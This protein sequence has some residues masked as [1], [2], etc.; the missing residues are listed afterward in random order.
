MKGKKPEA[1]SLSSLPNIN[2]FVVQILSVVPNEHGQ[3]INDLILQSN[4]QN[5]LI[6]DETLSQNLIK[7]APKGS[8]LEQLSKPQILRQLI[9]KELVQVRQEKQNLADGAPAKK[10]T[11]KA[12]PKKPAKGQKQVE[13]EEEEDYQGGWDVLAIA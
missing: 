7:S 10:T 8:N 5:F 6:L 9:A 12:P 4:Q 3:K 13:E 2:P 1:Q 11:K